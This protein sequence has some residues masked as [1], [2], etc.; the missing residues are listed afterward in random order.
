MIAYKIT[1]N[2]DFAGH[3]FLSDTFDRFQ[4]SEAVF[5]VPY[6]VSVDGA[7][8]SENGGT[9]VTWGTVRGFC[10]QLIKGKELPKSFHIVLKLSEENLTR[11]LAA[12]DKSIDPAKVSGLF[13][14]LR[15]D[16]NTF[17]LT[18]GTAVSDF[19]VMRSVGD[20]WDRLTLKFFQQHQIDL[21]A[22]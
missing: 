18:T 14:N 2:K 19:S 1:S 12:I 16:E 11:T 22:L 5:N 13:F 8:S 15:F 6:T 4:L 21:E 10:T 20:A 17:T 7:V 9:N 3:L